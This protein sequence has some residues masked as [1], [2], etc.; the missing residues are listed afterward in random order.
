MTEYTRRY[1]E[2]LNPCEN[3]CPTE[4]KIYG[5]R[6]QNIN[7]NMNYSYFNDKRPI[8]KTIKTYKPSSL[9]MNHDKSIIVFCNKN[10]KIC[11]PW[12]N[13]SDRAKPSNQRPYYINDDFKY[14]GCDIKH[15][16]YD[17]HLRRLKAN[18]LTKK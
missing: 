4:E 8:I 13:Q 17:R 2:T 1:H 9:I 11:K 7:L 3:I 18:I 14:I 15:N 12:H 5:H 10:G 6:K 16:H